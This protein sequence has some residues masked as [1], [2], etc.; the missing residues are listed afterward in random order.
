MRYLILLLALLM[1]GWACS[2]SSKDIQTASTTTTPIVSPTTTLVCAD[3]AQD[4]ESC[5]AEPPR[6]PEN[7]TQLTSFYTFHKTG[8]G[9]PS[10]LTISLP[11]RIEAGFF[12]VVP[13]VPQGN[14]AYFYSHSDAGWTRLIP[15]VI[16]SDLARGTFQTLP[17]NLIVLAEPE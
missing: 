12:D 6:L 7:A 11:T 13:T 17:E 5:R 15:A 8:T 14:R 2:D 10:G 3:I 4:F 9:A 16:E 1:V